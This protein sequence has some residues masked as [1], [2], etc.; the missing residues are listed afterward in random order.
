[1]K[2]SASYWIEALTDTSFVL[3][4]A[5]ARALGESGAR[6]AVPALMVALQDREP[7]VRDAAAEALGEFGPEAADAVAALVDARADAN[8]FVRRA[9]AR[10]LDKIRAAG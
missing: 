5:A 3:R 6:A 4:V 2:R 1:M 9:A 7:G 10:A 8:G